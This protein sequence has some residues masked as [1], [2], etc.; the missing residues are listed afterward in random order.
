VLVAGL[1]ALAWRSATPDRLDAAVASL[2]YARPGSLLRS[3]TDAVTLLGTPAAVALAS[4]LVAAW[5]WRRNP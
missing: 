1:T 4:F 3:G 2:L 5:A